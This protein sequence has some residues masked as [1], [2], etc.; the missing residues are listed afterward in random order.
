MAGCDAL[1]VGA[2]VVGCMTAL[3]LAE[4]GQRVVLLDRGRLGAESSWA[5]GGILFPLLPWNYGEPVIRLALI[6]AAS[7]PELAARLHSD[8]GIDPEYSVCGMQILPPFGQEPVLDWCARHGIPAQL[9]AEGMLWLPQV[10]QVRNP[11]LMQ[12]LRALLV[13]NGVEIREGIEML[14]LAATAGRLDRWSSVTGETFQADAYVVTAGAWSK[15]L[16]GEHAPGLDIR[17]MRGQMLLY[18]LPPSTLQH[19][20]YQEDFYLIPRRDGHILAGSTVED[21]GF[22]KNTTSAAASELHRKAC[23]L[24]PQLAGMS[25]LRHWSGLRPGSPHNIPVIARHPKFENLWLNSGHFRYGVTMAP[26]SA[27]ILRRLMLDGL[28]SS[29]DYAFPG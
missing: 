2:G 20:V 6:G 19:I 25:P 7:Y 22:D 18:R 27:E 21:V 15:Q 10:A 23:V 17:P 11:R 28:E 9:T 29:A 3:A 13:R 16:L 8:T 24:L 5:G 14:P 1:I 12:A 26:A 4:S